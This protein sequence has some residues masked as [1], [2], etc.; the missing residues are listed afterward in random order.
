VIGF[1]GNFE[2][3]NFFFC[4]VMFEKGFVRFSYKN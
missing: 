3:G 1:V 2:M 4:F